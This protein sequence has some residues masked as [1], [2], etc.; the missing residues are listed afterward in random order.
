[1]ASETRLSAKESPLFEPDPIVALEYSDNARGK[2][3]HM[4]EKMLMWAVLEDAIMW[5]QQHGLAQSSAGKR[6]SREARDWI[7]EEG[8]DW[9]FSF[10]NICAFLD[11]ERNTLR[12]G[13]MQPE[14]KLLDRPAEADHSPVRASKKP[15]KKR[16]Y[17]AAA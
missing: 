12:R 9:V 17:R 4:P 15:A 5:V 3:A 1:M 8:S 7:V 6:F 14:K 11:L 16:K 2:L 10:E 13:L